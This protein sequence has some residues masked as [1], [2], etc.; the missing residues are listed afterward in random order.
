MIS[1]ETQNRLGTLSP[2][3]Q[4]KAEKLVQRHL[5][6]CRKLGTPVESM[7]RVYIEAIDLVQKIPDI[8]EELEQAA[9][10]D[11]EKRSYGGTYGPPKEGE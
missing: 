8:L 10:Y 5:R 4:Q 7:D 2:E 9:N 1:K 11:Y 3:E 6:A